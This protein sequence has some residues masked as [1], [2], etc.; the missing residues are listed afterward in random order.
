MGKVKHPLIK[1]ENSFLVLGK[2]KNVK[3]ES[4]LRIKRSRSKKQSPKFTPRLRKG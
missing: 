2:R 3:D 1:P 4:H